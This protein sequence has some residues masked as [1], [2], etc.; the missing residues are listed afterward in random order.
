MAKL[1]FFREKPH[2][3]AANPEWKLIC[4]KWER[5]NDKEYSRLKGDSSCLPPICCK[6]FAPARSGHSGFTWMTAPSIE[7]RHPELVMVSVASA[8]VA[9]PDPD[10]PGLYRSWENR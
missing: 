7:I 6:C 3:A 5:Y 9:F 4:L 2:G 8:I 1:L 10:H